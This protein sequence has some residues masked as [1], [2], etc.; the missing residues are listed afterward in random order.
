MTVSAQ[1]IAS[2]EDRVAPSLRESSLDNLAGR[3]FED[4]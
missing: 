4:R 2:K 1:D 3:S